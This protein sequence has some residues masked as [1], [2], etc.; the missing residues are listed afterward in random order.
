M[1]NGY[2]DRSNLTANLGTELFKGFRIRSVTQLIYTRNTI[3]PGLGGPGGYQ[4]GK[5]NSLG[6][7]GQIF[8]SLNTSPFF[9]LRYKMADGTSPA[10]QTAGFVSV[11][12]FNPYYQKEYTS[13]ID[14]KV[15]ILQNFDA[16]YHVNKFVELDA[17]YGINFRNENSRWIYQNQTLNANSN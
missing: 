5:G 12:A 10:Y 2:L 17:K 14:N 3:V 6:N 13:G 4:Y 7:V 11:N 8:S 15:D 9:D 1:K 16:N